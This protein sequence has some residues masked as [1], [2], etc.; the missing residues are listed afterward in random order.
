MLFARIRHHI[1]RKR[2]QAM[3]RFWDE[4]IEEARKAHKPV[5]ALKAAKSQWVHDC[6]EGRGRA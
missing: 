5:R 3:V 1:A 6:L 2:F 4:Q